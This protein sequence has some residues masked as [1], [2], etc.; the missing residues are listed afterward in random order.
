MYN[1][2]LFELYK[3]SYDLMSPLQFK[4]YVVSQRLLRKKFN[5]KLKKVNNEFQDL[6]NSGK[7]GNSYNVIKYTSDD[8]M[9]VAKDVR[10]AE[11]T[12]KVLTDLQNKICELKK[13]F[14][15][16]R[17]NLFNSEH[18]IKDWEANELAF[19]DKLIANCIEMYDQTEPK[20]NKIQSVINDLKRK[21]SS[22]E[23]DE[24]EDRRKKQRKA[25]N[26]A[27]ARTD[28]EKRLFSSSF[29]L[30]RSILEGKLSEEEVTT[31]K[32]SGTFEN[33]SN[34]KINL[35]DFEKF[36][37]TSKLTARFH[38]EPL[39]N[40]IK[41]NIFYEDSAKEKA[42]EV[43]ESLKSK[44]VE[45]SAVN[46]NKAVKQAEKRKAENQQTKLNIEYFKKKC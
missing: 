14:I 33:F 41:H 5:D 8:S 23:A 44:A 18:K 45:T 6:I 46:K 17:S 36:M 25:E 13:M 19:Y 43:L 38:L 3:S 27:K 24:K 7:S 35:E 39:N 28:K 9:F 29:C 26:E 34:T 10:R 21:F 16:Y 22:D 11:N 1:D 4:N 42:T 37:K 30:Y 15:Q 12:L 20:C 40:L 32:D 31:V 2:I